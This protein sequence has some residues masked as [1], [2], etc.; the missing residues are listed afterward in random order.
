MDDAW[1]NEDALLSGAMC[2]GIGDAWEFLSFTVC[3]CNISGTY[4]LYFG[5][6]CLGL[7]FMFV[8]LKET[9]NKSLE[10]VQ[11]LFMSKEYKAKLALE[12]QQENE[13]NEKKDTA[14]TQF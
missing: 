5:I 11:E 9:K 10:E 6:C 8:L 4:W 7:T 13:K 1:V 14:N 2:N 12:R 3:F